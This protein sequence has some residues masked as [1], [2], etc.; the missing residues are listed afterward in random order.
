MIPRGTTTD[1]M[2]LMLILGFGLGGV[3]AVIAFGVLL[4]MKAHARDR[5]CSIV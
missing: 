3:V 4:G 1:K 5:P 2:W